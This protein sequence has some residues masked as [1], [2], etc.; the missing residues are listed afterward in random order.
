VHSLFVV[1][2]SFENAAHFTLVKI[3]H[4][5]FGSTLCIPYLIPI[6]GVHVIGYMHA[7]I[8]MVFPYW[9]VHE[10]LP[11]EDQQLSDVSLLHHA[12]VI[13]LISVAY[14]KSHIHTP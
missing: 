11:H 2:T 13:A 6:V 4:Y 5:E 3:S 12:V 1:F 8:F 7:G 9:V 10:L 14:T